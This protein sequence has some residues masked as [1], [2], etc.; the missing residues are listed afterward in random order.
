MAVVWLVRAE[1]PQGLVVRHVGC[2]P[3]HLLDGQL[4]PPQELHEVHQV[5]LPA[6]PSSVRRVQVDGDLGCLCG[7]QLDGVLDSLCVGLDRRLPAAARVIGVGGQVWQAVRLHDHH[8]GDLTGVLCEDLGKGIRVGLLVLF[9]TR[10]AIRLVGVVTP[11][12]WQVLAADLAV[13]GLGVAVPVRQVVPDEGHQLGGSLGRGVREDALQSPHARPADLRLD[14]DPVGRGDVAHLQEV[15][16]HHSCA[17]GDRRVVGHLVG[18]VL[19]EGLARER[20]PYEGD[21]GG[22]QGPRLPRV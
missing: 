20:V 15:I 17:G 6:E 10:V 2:K 11:A 12:V 1:R 16:L 21:V 9:K 22:L 13:G 5:V 4:H 18:R 7:E 14:V 8:D 19:V 3:A